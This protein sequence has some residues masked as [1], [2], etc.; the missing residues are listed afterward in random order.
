MRHADE[1]TEIRVL[2]VWLHFPI[3]AVRVDR[4]GNLW[5]LPTTDSEVKGIAMFARPTR[6]RHR[7]LCWTAALIALGW[8][9][10][11]PA[12]YWIGWPGSGV[13]QPPVIVNEETR[14]DHRD[15]KPP[16]DTPPTIDLPPTDE[17]RDN[18]SATPEPGTLLM[19]SGGLAIAAGLRKWRKRK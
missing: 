16:T 2:R 14:V 7:Q 6:F 15:P 19:L 13:Q 1:R 4:A 8:V 10:P 11:A 3:T 9:S 5:D 18:P 12:F 17:P